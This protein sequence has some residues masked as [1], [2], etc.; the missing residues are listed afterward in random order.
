MIAYIIRRLLVSIPIV[1]GVAFIVLIIFNVAG[2]DPVDMMMGKNTD[3]NALKALIEKHHLDKPL[4]L[5]V[6]SR[7]TRLLLST[8]T[9]DFADSFA[10]KRPVRDIFAERLMPT[11]FLSVPAFLAGA[12]IA[13]LLSLFIAFYRGS[14]ADFVV[15]FVAIGGISISSL[16]YILYGQAYLAHEWKLFPVWGFDSNILRAIVFLALPVT[17]WVSLALGA[18]IRYFR[19][20][21]LDQIRQDY[22]RTAKSIGHTDRTILLRHV[23]R[24]CWIPILTRLIV[25]VPFLIT[26]SFLLEIF[27][28]I[29]GLGTCLFNAI[30]ASDFP[31]LSAFTMLG[32]LL[33][34]FFNLLSDVAYAVV[35]PR[36]KLG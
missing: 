6:D 10:E 36:V 1:L 21:V 11:L 29:P 2:G 13:I 14:L 27:F 31:V 16:L 33:Y 24:N 18:D 4:I 32:S 30:S 25:Q 19:T 23:L 5:G 20:V 8:V 26:G 22:V 17:I 35:D 9:F 12:L 3:Q 34:V 15:T 28:G 7:Y